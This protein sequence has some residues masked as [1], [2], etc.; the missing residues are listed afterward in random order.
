MIERFTSLRAAKKRRP[1]KM[2]IA[3]FAACASTLALAQADIARA[4]FGAA[5]ESKRLVRVADVGPKPMIVA[6]GFKIGENENPRPQNRAK[7]KAPRKGSAPAAIG[8]EKTF[9]DGDFSIGRRLQS[10]GGATRR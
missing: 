10:G 2:R 5:S 9:L 4:N 7:V 1:M 3:I 8:F 6:G